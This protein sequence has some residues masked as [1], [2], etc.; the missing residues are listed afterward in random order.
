MHEKK[1]FISISSLR[2][3][4]KFCLNVFVVAFLKGFPCRL[5]KGVDN[6]TNFNSFI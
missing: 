3:I 2:K 4:L 5:R 6:I 1:F